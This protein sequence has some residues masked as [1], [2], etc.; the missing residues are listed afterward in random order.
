[1]LHFTRS[2]RLDIRRATREELPEVAELFSANGLVS[3]PTN[4]SLANVLLGLEE[5][6]IVGVVALEVVARFGL[7]RWLAVGAEHRGQGVARSLVQGLITRS[8][9]LGLREL[10]ALPGD[11]KAFLEDL[12]FR[13]VAASDVPR[14]VRML[15]SY[16]G[17]DQEAECEILQMTL[18][19]RV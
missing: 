15:P 11:A 4:P 8:Q 13:T 5:G 1:M 9:E 14:E 7:T 19:T 17:P 12:G 2:T 3:L 18:E 6:S 10:Y 16:S